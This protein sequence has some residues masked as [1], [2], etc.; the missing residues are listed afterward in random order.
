MDAAAA[1]LAD[2]IVAGEPIA[3]FG[4]YD[5]DG[6]ASAALLARFLAPPAREPTVYIPDRLFE[7]YGPNVEALRGLATR[8]PSFWSASTA[9]RPASRRLRK[10]A[11]SASTSW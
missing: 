6:A 11:A 1:R 3:I 2:A 4:D 5:V 9:A 8:A 7:G 10:R